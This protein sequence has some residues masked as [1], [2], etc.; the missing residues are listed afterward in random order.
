MVWGGGEIF[1]VVGGGGEEIGPAPR[2]EEK[3]VGGEGEGEGILAEGAEG[4]VG[5]ERVELEEVEWVFSTWEPH[6]LQ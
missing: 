6:S 2:G 4:E 1:E 3:S 5:G